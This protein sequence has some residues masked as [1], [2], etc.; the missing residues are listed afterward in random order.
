M[1][2]DFGAQ[3]D[4]VRSC[5]LRATERADDL[6]DAT[7]RLTNGADLFATYVLGNGGGRS[8]T[9]T[10]LACS[11]TPRR[12]FAPRSPNTRGG[13]REIT[14]GSSPR[15][16]RRCEAEGSI[17]RSRISTWATSSPRT[18]RRRQRRW[19]PPWP[20]R[21]SR[22][23]RRRSRRRSGLGDGLDE[24]EA[25]SDEAAT[26]SSPSDGSSSASASVASA[27]DLVRKRFSEDVS[28]L[29][30]AAGFN[31]A[32]AARLL[33]DEVREAVYSTVGAAGT[34]FFFAVFLSGFLDSLAEDVLAFSLTAAVGYVSVLSLPLKRAE[35]KAK[36]RAAAE[37]YL[38]E[39]EAAMRAEFARKT[40][41]ATT[42]VRATVAP[43]VESATAAEASVVAN[44]KTRATRSRRISISYSATC[45]ASDGS[46]RLRERRRESVLRDD[47]F[48]SRAS[49]R[50]Y[51]RKTNAPRVDD[52][53]WT[54]RSGH[55]R[56][57]LRSLRLV[58]RFRVSRRRRSRVGT[59][60]SLSCSWRTVLTRPRRSRG[61]T[62]SPGR[63][64]FASRDER[65]RRLSRA[66][67]RRRRASS[68]HPSSRT[69]RRAC[70]LAES[71]VLR[72]RV[73]PGTPSGRRGAP[74]PTLARF[75]RAS[76]ARAA[77]RAT[78]PRT[79]RPRAMFPR[80]LPDSRATSSPPPSPRGSAAPPS[81][82]STAGW[83]T[84]PPNNPSARG[85]SRP[86]SPSSPPRA[87][88][89]RSIL[90]ARPATS[91][92]PPPR[93]P[94]PT[95]PPRPHRTRTTTPD[96]LG[97]HRPARRAPEG[98]GEAPVPLRGSRRRRQARDG[99]RQGSMHVPRGGGRRRD[100]REERPR[101]RRGR[102][103]GR[104]V[105]LRSTRSRRP[106]RRFLRLQSH[107]HG[108]RARERRRKKNPRRRRPV[109][110]V[111]RVANIACVR[112]EPPHP[113]P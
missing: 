58:P 47:P 100:A 66:R 68:P 78:S 81:P 48:T 110:N 50:K 31:N 69:P 61:R 2:A 21:R 53:S 17:P 87:R 90:G 83:T 56:T 29:A 5:V 39:V 105:Q 28:P 96:T 19:K 27:A 84:P 3:L 30:V 7:L 24:A 82:G 99:S 51:A 65:R 42:Q 37:E 15:T 71:A 40:T 23:R 10:G 86:A 74:T 46:R 75:S 80:R 108:T 98:R 52:S 60:P 94:P 73:S 8:E 12:S 55:P 107:R 102:R 77:P 54:G 32:A 85:P 34:A 104:R 18:A 38:G 101:A 72:R 63:S 13:W 97:H 25:D 9:R 57:P 113:E 111:R 41:A 35:T 36:V 89:A 88:T 64:H 92:T 11:E 20:K 43:W 103:G 6:L 112:S 33:E 16:R 62:A 59:P 67:P 109:S 93:T 45:R 106:R 70:S 1:E 95:S 76:R 22:R 79:R 26:P 14:R 49:S 44:Q 91:P 4:A